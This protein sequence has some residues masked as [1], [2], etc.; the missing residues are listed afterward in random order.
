[1]G[2]QIIGT[3][4]SL[5]VR[6]SY[7]LYIHIYIFEDLLMFLSFFFAHSSIKYK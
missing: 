6:E 7:L 2:C 4:L 5:E 1:M 3:I